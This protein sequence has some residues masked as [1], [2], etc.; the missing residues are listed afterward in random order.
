MVRPAPKRFSLLAA[1]AVAVLL[2]GGCTSAHENV[3][4]PADEQVVGAWGNAQDG[5]ELVVFGSDHSVK[6]N[7]LPLLV[8][9]DLKISS[10]PAEGTW[11]V[12]QWSADAPPDVVLELTS[13]PQ[14]DFSTSLLVRW[15][16]ET[17]VLFTLIGDPDEGNGYELRR[18]ID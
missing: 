2:V 10:L 15:D 11:R 7:K 1:F 6:I 18:S 14:A 13:E 16:G 4:V 12:H 9:D 8:L 17:L 5:D 3:A